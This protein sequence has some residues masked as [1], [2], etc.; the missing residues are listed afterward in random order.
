M[1]HPI[2]T[3]IAL[4]TMGKFYCDGVAQTNE[5]CDRNNELQTSAAIAMML[6]KAQV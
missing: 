3:T 1:L 5:C 4:E 6:A 2:A